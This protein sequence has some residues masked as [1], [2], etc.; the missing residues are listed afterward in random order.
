MPER[1]DVTV[2][3]SPSRQRSVF[4]SDTHHAHVA[5]VVPDW[6]QV[7][8]SSL[9][10]ESRQLLDLFCW[11][12]FVKYLGLPAV[13]SPIGIDAKRHPTC[14]QV[15]GRPGTETMLLSLARDTESS[16]F[17]GS[18]YFDQTALAVH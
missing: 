16:L 3:E 17:K 10:F 1:G 4:A 12:S 5:L 15:I 7:Q 18:T 2:K 13:V 8:T 14:A 11:M 9:Q 6:T